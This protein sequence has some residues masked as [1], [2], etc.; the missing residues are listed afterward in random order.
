MLWRRVEVEMIGWVWEVQIGLRGM[1]VMNRSS[2]GGS[3]ERLGR[4]G[5]LRAKQRLLDTH[6]PWG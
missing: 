2:T 3:R 6:P 4:I 1:L 5:V